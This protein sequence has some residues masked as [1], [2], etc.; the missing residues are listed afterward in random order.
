M[1]V[2]IDSVAVVKTYLQQVDNSIIQV[3]C[4]IPLT[5]RKRDDYLPVYMV[6]EP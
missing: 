1:H 5:E 6:V 4:A 3:R 2:V